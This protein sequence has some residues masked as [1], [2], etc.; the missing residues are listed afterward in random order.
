MA[1]GQKKREWFQLGAQ[2]FAR[3]RPG[4]YDR[5]TYPCPICLT[6][7]AIDA[8][9]DRTLSAEHVPPETL[10]GRELLLTC[11]A[12]NNSAGSKLDAHAKVKEDVRLAL[13]G[14]LKRPHRIKASFG[15]IRVNGDLL[16]SKDGYSLHIPAKINKPSTSE[17]LVNVARAGAQVT[18]EHE[19]FADL[20]AKISWFR[21]GYLALFTVNGYEFALDPAFEIVRKQIM[22]CDERK[23]ITFTTEAPEDIPLTVRRILRVIEPEWHGGWA[24][25]F[26]P[27]FVH[28]PALGDMSLYDR[29]AEHAYDPPAQYSYRYIVWPGE[30]TFGLA[31][32][33]EQRLP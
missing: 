32:I 6:P 22:E 28:F 9:T 3:V 19:R 14:A 20:G 10:G 15:E 29:M 33:A 24:V 2:A 5:P 13:A 7:F 31:P 12:C 4:M 27:Y 1:S 25:E 23:M 16:A 8:L 26:G 30:P 21:S 18:V 11:T 17:A